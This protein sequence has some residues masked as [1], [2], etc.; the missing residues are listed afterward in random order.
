MNGFDVADESLAVKW[1]VEA[2]DP[3]Q[4]HAT[5]QSRDVLDISRI[6]PYPL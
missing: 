2:D 4:I 5:L 3:N 1:L 6:T